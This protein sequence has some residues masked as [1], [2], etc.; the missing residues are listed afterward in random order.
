MCAVCQR[1]GLKILKPSGYC[2]DCY[3]QYQDAEK[4]IY[5]Q[6]LDTNLNDQKCIE[7]K[8]RWPMLG[9]NYCGTCFPLSL[10]K[11]TNP[12]NKLVRLCKKCYTNKV[13][14]QT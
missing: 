4:Q 9:Q 3:S 14:S 11:K 5:Q 12:I 10:G 1:N 6:Q 7:C 8:I 13:E 2:L